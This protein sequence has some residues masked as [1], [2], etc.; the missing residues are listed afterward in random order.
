MATVPALPRDGAVRVPAWA[1]H[2]QSRPA[3]G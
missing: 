3:D 2:T 1:T